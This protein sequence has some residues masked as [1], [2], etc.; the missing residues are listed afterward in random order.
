MTD[1]KITRCDNQELVRYTLARATL[2]KACGQLDRL[3]HRLECMKNPDRA[4]RFVPSVVP[5]TETLSDVLVEMDKLV[6]PTLA[7]R[8]ELDGLPTGTYADI[9]RTAKI[10]GFTLS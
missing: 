7:A 6:Q 2:L 3:L 4:I 10:L 9:A 5:K 8:T 1:Y